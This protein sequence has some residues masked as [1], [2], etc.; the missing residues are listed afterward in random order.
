MQTKKNPRN[1][2]QATAG[3]KGLQIGRQ[4]HGPYETFIEKNY[5]GE[6]T[7]EKGHV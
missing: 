4:G 5:T 7:D 1:K 6:A 2:A 3:T